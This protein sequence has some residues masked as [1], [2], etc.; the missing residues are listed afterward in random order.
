[1]S[2]TKLELPHSFI[3]ETDIPLRISDINYGGHLGNDAVLSIIHE[4]RVRFLIRHG[5]TEFDL[6]GAGLIMVDAVIVY[7]SESYYGETLR[8]ELTVDDLQPKGFDF[9]YR[10]SEKETGREVARA[11]TSVVCF[12]YQ[13]RKVVH[14]P[15]NF[16]ELIS[17][18]LRGQATT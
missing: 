13:N 11:K 15:A 10:L 8:C 1:M 14:V 6:G 3:F 2:R 12:D 9:L 7:R 4:A 16:S 5:F 17:T 18:L